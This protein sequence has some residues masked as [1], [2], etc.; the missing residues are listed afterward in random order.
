MF[1]GRYRILK[2]IAKGKGPD[3][4]QM[5]RVFEDGEVQVQY[6]HSVVWSDQLP[7]ASEDLLRWSI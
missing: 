3:M 2:L 1:P 4:H 7:F 5:L 6:V